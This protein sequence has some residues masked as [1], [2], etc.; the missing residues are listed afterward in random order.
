[1]T[2]LRLQNLESTGLVVKAVLSFMTMM[3]QVY[4]QY[5]AQNGL[6]VNTVFLSVIKL[7][8]S[9]KRPKMSCPLQKYV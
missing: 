9:L 5:W 3:L 6:F 7:Y 8:Y 4:S 2:T 1:M